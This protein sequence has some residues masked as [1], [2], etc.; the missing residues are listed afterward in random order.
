MS[1]LLG[2]YPEKRGLLIGLHIGA[3]CRFPWPYFID[4]TTLGF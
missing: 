2:F 1:V 3:N 4:G